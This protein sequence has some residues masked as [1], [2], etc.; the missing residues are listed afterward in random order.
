MKKKLN[1]VYLSGAPRVSTRSIAEMSGPRTH[2]LGII[3]GFSQIGWNVEA[4]IFGDQ[5]PE[6][7]IIKGSEAELSSSKIRAFASDLIRIYF[8]LR[9]AFKAYNLY[10]QTADLVYERFGSFQ[11]LGRRFKRNGIFWI[12][13]TNALLSLESTSQ[14]KTLALGNLARRFERNAYENCDMLV[15][16]SEPLKKLIV[17]EFDIDA[18]KIIVVPNGVDTS[19]IDPSNFTAKREFSG[20]T[21]G[22]VGS[23][24]SWAGLDNLITIIGRL[25]G[26][27]LIINLTIVGDGPTKSS[28]EK[29]STELALNNQIKFLGQQNWTDVPSYIAGFDVC[30]SGQVKFGSGEMY[31]SPLKLYEYMAMAKPVIVSAFWDAQCLVEDGKTGFLFEPGDNVALEEVI[32]HVYKSRSNLIEMGIRAREVVEKN[33]SWR[34]RVAKILNRVSEIKESY[35]IYEA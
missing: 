20:F 6:K 17:S 25:K 7:W 28:L 14:R 23:L 8:G 21:I 12:L 11:A 5:V 10:K 4:F 22:F 18:S 3:D 24:Y 34:I 29:L 19:R 15:C 16:I 2:V 26:A 1:L 31:L 32:M 33:H 9:N 27:G 30:Y 13:E 35:K